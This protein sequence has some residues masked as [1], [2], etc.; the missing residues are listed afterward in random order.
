MLHAADHL[1]FAAWLEVNHQSAAEVWL[2]IATKGS[3]LPSVTA[4]EAIDVALC[5]GW[6][7]GQRKALDDQHF[8]QRYCPRR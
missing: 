2:A 7:D 8:L 3:G 4:S 5:F 1:Q 6:I